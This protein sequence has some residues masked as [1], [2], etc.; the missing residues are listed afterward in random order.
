MRQLIEAAYSLE[1][2]QL[3]GGPVWLDDFFDVEATT[4]E[5]MSGETDRVLALGS[6]APRKMMVMLQNLLA[7]RCN[8]KVHR[9][10][11]QDN[12]YSMVL[13]KAPSKRVTTTFG[14]ST[15][16]MV[17]RLSTSRSSLPLLRKRQ[18]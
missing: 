15:R 3:S 4:A 14:S 13:A 18:A 11:R 2:W 16:L 1:R 6:P 7:E 9:E 17:L 8:L 10:T 12:V 5:D